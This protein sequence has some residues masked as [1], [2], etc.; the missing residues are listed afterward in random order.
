MGGAACRRCRKAA[1]VSHH[2]CWGGLF[3]STRAPHTLVRN[4][5]ELTASPSWTWMEFFFNNNKF[6]NKILLL[7]KKKPTLLCF[8]LSLRKELVMG[9]AV[10]GWAGTHRWRVQDGNTAL[11]LLSRALVAALLRA[12]RWDCASITVLVMHRSQPSP[13]AQ[14]RFRVLEGFTTAPSFWDGARFKGP[15]YLSQG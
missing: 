12:T 10:S 7:I 1:S 2:P 13:Q 5:K 9:I 11:C 4:S 15:S 6:N 14:R 8:S 3:S